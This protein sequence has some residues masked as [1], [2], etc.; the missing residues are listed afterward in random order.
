MNRAFAS[1]ITAMAFADSRMGRRLLAPPDRPRAD[2]RSL[3]GRL[4]GDP[5]RGRSALDRERGP[6][7]VTP[8][9]QI[10]ASP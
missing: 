7:A 4:C 5:R 8:W 10:G 1:A 2:D 3:T 6:V 9:W